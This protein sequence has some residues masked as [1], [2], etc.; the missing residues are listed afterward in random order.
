MEETE[1]SIRQPAIAEQVEQF[2][3]DVA[4]QK[5]LVNTDCHLDIEWHIDRSSDPQFVP[6]A[7][8]RAKQAFDLPDQSFVRLFPLFRI[9]RDEHLVPAAGPP[10]TGRCPLDSGMALR[11]LRIILGRDRSLQIRSKR[12]R[13]EELDL[14]YRLRVCPAGRWFGIA[15]LECDAAQHV[16]ENDMRDR[17]G[18]DIADRPETD[19]VAGE[20]VLASL[21]CSTCIPVPEPQMRQRTIIDLD[22]KVRIFSAAA[23][24]IVTGAPIDLGQTIRRHA[25][26]PDLR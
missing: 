16:L 13:G 4:A 26:Q 24:Q 19:A 9:E 21:W 18:S 20:E 15:R 8:E 1:P 14:R 25:P 6:D 11:Q 17:F 10:Q 22:H 12:M 3:F 7:A 23:Q 5:T 2:Q